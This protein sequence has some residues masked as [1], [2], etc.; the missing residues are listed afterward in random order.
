MVSHSL[1]LG[2]SWF[3]GK[4]SL[5]SKF[6]GEVGFRCFMSAVHIAAQRYVW[7][8]IHW[9]GDAIMCSSPHTLSLCEHWSLSTNRNEK[10]VPGVG[11]NVPTK[12]QHKHTKLLSFQAIICSYRFQCMLLAL[13]VMKEPLQWRWRGRTNLWLLEGAQIHGSSLLGA[14]SGA[15]QF[16]YCGQSVLCHACTSWLIFIWFCCHLLENVS[17]FSETWTALVMSHPKESPS[18]L[19]IESPLGW[20]HSRVSN[21]PISCYL[22]FPNKTSCYLTLSAAIMR[23]AQ[24]RVLWGF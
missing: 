10:T 17:C 12:R 23:P 5:T 14:S 22:I 3:I 24:Q 16:W 21:L 19:V 11:N 8:L 20:I 2:R 4:Q 7:F 13:S 6:S 18:K 9:S 15:R 1:L